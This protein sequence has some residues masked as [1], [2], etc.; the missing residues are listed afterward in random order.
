MS[1]TDDKKGPRVE[2][3]EL[4]NRLRDKLAIEQRGE[5]VEGQI[6]PAAIE[7]ADEI[8]ARRCAEECQENMVAQMEQLKSLWDEMKDM[9]DSGARD[10]LAQQVV[11]TAHEVKDIGAMCDYPLAAHFGESLRD[12]VSHTDLKLA[13]QRVII[14]AHVDVLNIAIKENLRETDSPAAEELKRML[15][16]AVDQ[17]S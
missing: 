10:E 14:Q 1:A 5:H 11:T 12:F 16:V 6:D 4:H 9:P 3:Y 17:Y 8:I 7:E 15:K 2:K 13:A